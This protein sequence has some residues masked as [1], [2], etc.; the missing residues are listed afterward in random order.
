MEPA[1]SHSA[2][3]RS[4]DWANPAAVSKNPTRFGF[5]SLNRQRNL[6]PV[7]NVCE[8]AVRALFWTPTGFNELPE[9]CFEFPFNMIGE[10]AMASLTG[11]SWRVLK[12]WYRRPRTKNLGVV[13]QTFFAGVWLRYVCN[14]GYVFIAV[15]L[16]GAVVQHSRTEFAETSRKITVADKHWVPFGGTKAL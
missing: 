9:V 14:T 15:T 5:H 1:T 7:S 10:L 8:A 2:V 16:F 11:Q 6:T 3:K 13:S 12:S 4:T